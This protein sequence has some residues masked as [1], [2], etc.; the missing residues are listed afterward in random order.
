MEASYYSVYRIGAS[1]KNILQ[2]CLQRPVIAVGVHKDNGCLTDTKACQRHHF[3]DLIMQS[4]EH[5]GEDVGDGE[6]VLL[7]RGYF[8]LV[9]LNSFYLDGEYVFYD[10][11]FVVEHFP[12]NVLLLRL[13]NLAYDSTAGQAC[14][15]LPMQELY[16]RYGL[17]RHLLKWQQMESKFLQKLRKEKELRKEQKRRE[18]EARKKQREKE[19]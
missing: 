16:R 8:D 15:A 7:S 18:K 14:L 9:P 13:V 4:S 6:G 17:D 11:E 10:Q 12:A 5:D 1:I 19:E 3:R 2:N